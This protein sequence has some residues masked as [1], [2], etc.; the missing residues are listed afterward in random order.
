MNVGKRAYLAVVGLFSM[1]VAGIASAALPAEATA[2]FTDVTTAVTDVVAA[3]WP[4]VALVLV[5]FI[6]IKLVKKGANKAT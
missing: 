5:S 2:A 1:M 6:T 3:I 4:I